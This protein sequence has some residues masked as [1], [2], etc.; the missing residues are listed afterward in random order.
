MNV[1]SAEY[2]F[3]APIY[4]DNWSTFESGLNVNMWKAEEKFKAYSINTP[5]TNFLGLTHSEDYPIMSGKAY[6]GEIQKSGNPILTSLNHC[7]ISFLDRKGNSLPGLGEEK[8]IIDSIFKLYVAPNKKCA[9]FV[10]KLISSKTSIDKAVNTVYA[11]HKT[12]SR[13]I[14]FIYS[15]EDAPAFTLIDLIKFSL[16]E[17]CYSLESQS[18]FITSSYIKVDKF[19]DGYSEEQICDTLLRLSLS[20]NNKYEL[21][22]YDSNRI[23]KVFDNILT[24]S[25]R[26]GFATIVVSKTDENNQFIKEF[27][28]TFE[29]AYLPLYLA[30]TLVD[31]MY[32]NAIRSID[33]I[34][35]NLREQDFFLD[36]KLVSSLPPSSYDHLNKLMESILSTRRLDDIY[37]NVMAKISF[38]IEQVECEKLELEKSNKKLIQE[39]RA[40]EEKR[41]R[42]ISMLLGFIGVGQVIFAILQLLGA[43]HILGCRVAYSQ[44]VNYMSIFFSAAFFG[45]IL[46]YIASLCHA[47]RG[48]VK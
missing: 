48:T 37:N 16:P 22:S 38:R 31:Q 40:K 26:E 27:S 47:K 4:I 12:D 36:A 14:P 11:L 18:R 1:L 30:V 44:F 41:D 6:K 25:S 2:Y 46:W 17:N 32:F 21:T 20:K 3:I 35:G 13:Q 24:C 34:A 42:N 8:I 7:K 19:K 23:H 43:N 28:N 5:L 29:R 45:A 9:L 33:E 10:L 15:R 39:I